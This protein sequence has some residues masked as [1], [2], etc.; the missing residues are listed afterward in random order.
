VTERT[1]DP[2]GDG[3]VGG[4]RSVLATA[5]AC[6]RSVG[7]A[8]EAPRSLPGGRVPLAAG[9]RTREWSCLWILRPGG[10]REDPGGVDAAE[11]RP[12]LRNRGSGIGPGELREASPLAAPP[13][14]WDLACVLRLR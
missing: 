14:P 11:G 6:L 12:A 9:R 1:T 2:E 7:D 3:G 5:A 10:G 4:T 13:G 8:R